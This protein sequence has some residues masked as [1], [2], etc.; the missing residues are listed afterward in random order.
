MPPIVLQHIQARR[1]PGV[2]QQIE[3]HHRVP[4][5]AIHPSTNFEPMNPAPR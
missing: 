5:D 1:I 2:G 4:P 3:I